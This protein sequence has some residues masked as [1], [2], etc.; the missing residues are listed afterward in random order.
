MSPNPPYVADPHAVVALIRDIHERTDFTGRRGTEKLHP[1]NYGPSGQK[2]RTLVSELNAMIPEEYSYHEVGIYRGRTILTS[3]LENPGKRHVGVDNFSQFDKDGENEGA[4]RATIAERDVTNLEL[5]TGDFI[6]H[7]AEHEDLN[8]RD[9]GV[10]FYDAIHDYRNQL[11]GLMYGARIIAPGGILLID[12]TNYGHVRHSTY[13]FVRAN[14]EYKLVFETFT[15]AHP[16]TMTPERAAEVRDGW[17]NGT[18]VMIYDPE[19]RIASIQGVRESKVEA[20]FARA[21]TQTSAECHTLPT[22]FVDA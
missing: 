2:F 21:V 3:A 7:Y 19:H 22:R 18:Q 4:I 11:V 17:W 1:R 5:K 16:T 13:D 20:A 12:D 10:F 6:E 8:T 15:G 9:C 14:P